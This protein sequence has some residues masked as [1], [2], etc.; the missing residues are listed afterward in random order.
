VEP[1]TEALAPI[2][3][4]EFDEVSSADAAAELMP[5]CASRRWIAQVV[6]ERP[7]GSLA[8]LTRHSNEIIAQ[9]SWSEVLE[10][11]AAHPRIGDRAA[12]K[13][14][15]A[16]WSRQEQAG[17][18]AISDHTRLELVAANRAY[19]E[20]FGHVFLIC[21]TGLTSTQMLG[22]ARSRLRNDPVAEQQV[23]R[24]ELAKIV[25]I[26]LARAVR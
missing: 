2:A 14:R 8:A 6:A 22:A 1:V 16:G 9:L 25:A 21:A 10:A 12:D 7:Y 20:Q 15:E 11:L 23:V 26:R 19:E 24:T 3:I 13:G 17:T 5:C 4:A 18:A